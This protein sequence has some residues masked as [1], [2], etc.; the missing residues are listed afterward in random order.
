MGI[1]QIYLKD[2]ESRGLWGCMS[3][4]QSA[5]QQYSTA[6]F[7]SCSIPLQGTVQYFYRTM[8][9]NKSYLSFIN[10][11]LERKIEL[12]DGAVEFLLSATLSLAACDLTFFIL[13]VWYCDWFL[14]KGMK[15]RS[16]YPVMWKNLTK[17]VIY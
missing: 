8:W 6:L 4:T 7:P 5:F 16:T 17:P 3:W 11:I 15:T 10:L 12:E 14:R 13:R 2:R 9:E 1:S